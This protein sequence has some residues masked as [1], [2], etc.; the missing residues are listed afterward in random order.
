MLG[1][2]LVK[3]I[4]GNITFMSSYINIQYTENTVY[5]TLLK[6]FKL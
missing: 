5:I 1:T 4:A 6:L 3:K 2:L